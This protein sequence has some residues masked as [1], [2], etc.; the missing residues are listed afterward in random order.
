MPL[1]KIRFLEVFP[2]QEQERRMLVETDDFLATGT[3]A[4][5]AQSSVSWDNITGKPEA[6][7]PAV[8]SHPELEELIW[9]LS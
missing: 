4:A 3:D 1:K 9:F 5:A 7:A 6:F 8:H 2:A